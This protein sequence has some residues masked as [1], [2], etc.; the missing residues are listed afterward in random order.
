MMLRRAIEP[1]AAQ[2]WSIL[3][4]SPHPPTQSASRPTSRR[5]QPPQ[6]RSSCTSTDTVPLSMCDTRHRPGIDLTI[7]RQSNPSATST[8]LL[9]QSAANMQGADTF[10]APSMPIDVVSGFRGL[11]VLCIGDAMLDTYIEGTAT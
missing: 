5:L 1:V 9:N 8:N 2:S 6:P 3:E 10:S 7:L 11:R 4:Q